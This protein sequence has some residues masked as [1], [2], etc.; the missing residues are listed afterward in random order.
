MLTKNI[1]VKHHIKVYFLYDNSKLPKIPEE[2]KKDFQE[3]DSEIISFYQDK[4]V[5]ILVSLGN[6]KTIDIDKLQKDS[7]RCKKTS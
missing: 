5:V 1:D 2:V 6:R 3:E 4:K 7:K